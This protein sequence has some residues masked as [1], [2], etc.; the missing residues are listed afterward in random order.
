MRDTLIMQLL[1]QIGRLGAAR[2]TE[3]RYDGKIRETL[4]YINENL[5]AEMSVDL[6]ADRV[7]L[8]RYHFM[9]LFKAQTGSTVHAYIRQKRLLAAARL[10]REGTAAAR[11][12]ADLGFGD[13][14]SFHR[15]FRSSF[16]ISPG[17]LKK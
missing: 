4:S 12:A 13:Y 15:A 17:E 1:V 2:E 6:L 7:Y 9:R 11:A 5:G 16:G 3:R 8:S 14:S 10:I